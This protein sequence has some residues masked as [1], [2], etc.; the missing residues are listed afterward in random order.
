MRNKR[1][2]CMRS[3]RGSRNPWFMSNVF[4]RVYFWKESLCSDPIG[5]DSTTNEAGVG[6]VQKMHAKWKIPPSI[7]NSK[8][9][10]W[11]WGLP[12]SQLQADFG[13]CAKSNQKAVW[14]IWPRSNLHLTPLTGT[15]YDFISELIKNKSTE[16]FNRWQRSRTKRVQGRDSRGF[17]SFLWSPLDV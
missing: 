17:E 11:I 5:F 4:W 14:W 13:C 1:N 12:E 15:Q 6:D 8:A 9:W 10:L 16:D 3:S 2:L 7:F